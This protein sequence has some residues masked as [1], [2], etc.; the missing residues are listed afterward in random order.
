[1]RCWGCV[2]A[3]CKYAYFIVWF[4]KDGVFKS[5]GNRVSKKLRD[6]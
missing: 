4:Q 5:D 3:R 2:G 6:F 1:M